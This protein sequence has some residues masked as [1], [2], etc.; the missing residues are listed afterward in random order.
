MGRVAWLLFKMA[1]E[2]V[3]RVKLP[4][5]WRHGPHARVGSVS[6][7][8]YKKDASYKAFL[9]I[10]A[11][12]TYALFLNN[13]LARPTNR[14]VPRGQNAPLLMTWQRRSLWPYYAG[15]RLEEV[16]QW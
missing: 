9:K 3:Q 6:F 1:S 5:R 14:Y 11:R 13:S 7:C 2:A 4:N 10:A 12:R 8:I 16:I 15:S